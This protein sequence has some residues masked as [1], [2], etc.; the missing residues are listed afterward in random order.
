MYWIVCRNSRFILQGF[1]SY[2]L[3]A[4][5]HL[6]L[7]EN[8]VCK[9]LELACVMMAALSSVPG[10]KKGKRHP[11]WKFP[12]S[13]CCQLV[14]CNQK[15]LFCDLCYCW[16]HSR[17]SDVSDTQYVRLTALGPVSP[18]Y[19]PAYTIQ[20]LPFTDYSLV[21]DS[22]SSISDVSF[23]KEDHPLLCNS[24][25]GLCHINIRSLMA[26]SQQFPDI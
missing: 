24:S 14:K 9:F 12:C 3:P 19:C 2:E 26:Y 6:I 8:Y 20:Q 11:L 4:F 1:K 25:L 22:V 15:G 16:C 17:C 5:Q 23:D 7:Q 21:S 18:W 10:K 13:I